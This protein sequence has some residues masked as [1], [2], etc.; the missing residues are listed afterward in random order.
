MSNSPK[1][2]KKIKIFGITLNRKA[3]VR[4]KIY[5]DRA[6]MYLGYINFVMIAFVFLNSF[7]D[8]QIR[9]LL[10]EYKLIIYPVIMLLFVGIS[11]FLGRLDTKL[12]MRKEE[13]RNNATE[14]PV[15]MEILDSLQ[16]IKIAQE[17]FAMKGKG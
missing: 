5:L 4:W 10:D 14:N 12:G 7:Q 2:R 11:F 1:P 17:A 9:H 15:M 6:R 8:V 16:E 13:M 3:V